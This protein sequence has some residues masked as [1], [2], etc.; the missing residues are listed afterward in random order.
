MNTPESRKK[1]QKSD[2]E[3]ISLS[4]VFHS[5][6]LLEVRF[7]DVQFTYSKIYPLVYNVVSFNE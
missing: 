1:K 4:V 5:L 7:I 3:T 6:S 2:T